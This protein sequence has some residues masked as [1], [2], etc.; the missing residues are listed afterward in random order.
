MERWHRGLVVGGPFHTASKRSLVT[1]LRCCARCA[2]APT[3]LSSDGKPD[4]LQ[5]HVRNELTATHEHPAKAVPKGLEGYPVLPLAP[6]VSTMPLQKI[7]PSDNIIF[8]AECNIFKSI[9]YME[10]IK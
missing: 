6:C 2:G 3:C 10:K 9:H 8:F 1:S 4:S 5:L 7:P